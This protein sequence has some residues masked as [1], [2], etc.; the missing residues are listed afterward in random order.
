MESNDTVFMGGDIVRKG[1]RIR[2]YFLLSF[3]TLIFGKAWEPKSKLYTEI[4]KEN[5]YLYL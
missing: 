5:I 3:L 1:E 4:K 2:S